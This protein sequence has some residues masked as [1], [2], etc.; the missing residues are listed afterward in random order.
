MPRT[1]RILVTLLVAVFL[2]GG[3]WAMLQSVAWTGMFVNYIRDFSLTDALEK[4]F[5]GEDPCPMCCAVKKGREQEK[6]QGDRAVVEG[7]KMAFALPGHIDLRTSLGSRGVR[8]VPSDLFS[9]GERGR[10]PA[11]RPPIFDA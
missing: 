2:T 7:A 3:Q 9:P 5:D 1:F 10:K 4:T 8:L 11:L 6:R